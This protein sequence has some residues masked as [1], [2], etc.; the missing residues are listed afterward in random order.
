VA[1]VGDAADLKKGQCVQ[2]RRLVVLE[3]PGL[4]FQEAQVVWKPIG[5]YG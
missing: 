2:Q 3:R 4:R 1:R 5:R